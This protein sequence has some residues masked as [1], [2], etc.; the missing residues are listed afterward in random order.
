M[1][2]LPDAV[3][4][5]SADAELNLPAERDLA[6]NRALG[7]RSEHSIRNEML[8]CEGIIEE[9]SNMRGFKDAS[10]RAMLQRVG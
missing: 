6:A 2:T 1:C 10:V 5:L 4:T 3:A 7:M 9:Y 8:V